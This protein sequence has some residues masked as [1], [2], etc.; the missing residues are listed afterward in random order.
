M[1]DIVGKNIQCPQCNS[2]MYFDPVDICFQCPTCHASSPAFTD[3]DTD[4]LIRKNN[5][6]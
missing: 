3:E 5:N 1:P 6:G 4:H 2:V